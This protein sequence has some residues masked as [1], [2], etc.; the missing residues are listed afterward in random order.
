M[1]FLC[2]IQSTKFLTSVGQYVSC[3]YSLHVH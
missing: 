1:V 3:L 2:A